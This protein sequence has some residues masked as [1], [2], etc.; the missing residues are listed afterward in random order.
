MPEVDTSRMAGAES[1]V[2]WFGCWPDFHDAEVLE[3]CLRREGRSSV[4]IHAWR[5]TMEI[6]SNG[7]FVRDHHV[8]VSFGFDG[9]QDLQLAD[10]STQNVIAS[11]HCESTENG[12]RVTLSPCFGVSGYIE[13]E[14]VSVS[15]Q[16]GNPNSSDRG[17][18][19]N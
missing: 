6:D 1:V 9:V 2:E 12:F 4:R 10:F 16:P 8:V 3:I 15:L 5:P 17:R 19:S 18:G 14:R 13:A 7:Y 11:L